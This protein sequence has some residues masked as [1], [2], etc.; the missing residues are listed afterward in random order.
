MDIQ[1]FINDWLAA[2]NAYDTDKY[3]NFFTTDA[4]LDDPLIGRK[5]E[6]DKGIQHY[7]ESYFIGY[8]T[9]TEQI[10]LKIIDEANVHLEVLFTGDFPEGK[11]GGAF[12]FEF[13]EGKIAFLRADL[14]H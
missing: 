7:F 5:F 9:Y 2:S 13:K 1:Q 11:I 12:D 4:V 10:K 6:K 14:I 3:L 8:N